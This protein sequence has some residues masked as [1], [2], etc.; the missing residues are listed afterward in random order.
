LRSTSRTG[1]S[2]RSRAALPLQ[3]IGI[4]TALCALAAYPAYRFGGQASLQLM[5]L[6]AVLSCATVVASYTILVLAFRHV[7]QLQVVIVVGGFLIR[8]VILFGALTVISKTLVV[9]LGQL[10]IWIVVFYMVLVVA[11]AWF[12]VSSSTTKRTGA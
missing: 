9:D 11:E 8:F 10:V 2:R 4:Q 3:L 5:L 7:R 12:L 1:R 6:G